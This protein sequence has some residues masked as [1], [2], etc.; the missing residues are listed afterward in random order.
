MIREAGTFLLKYTIAYI[1]GGLLIVG[2]L[3]LFLK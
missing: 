1:L 2:G 3:R